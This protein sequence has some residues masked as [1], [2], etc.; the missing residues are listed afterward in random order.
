MLVNKIE[1]VVYFLYDND[2]DDS[3]GTRPI[4]DFLGSFIGGIQ[5]DA[6]AVYRFFADVNEANERSLCW[7]HVRAKSKYASD[8][9]KDKDASW[10]VEQ[11]GRLYAVEVENRI[12]GR[13]VDEIKERRNRTDVTEIL[14]GLLSRANRMLKDTKIH[15]GDMMDTALNYMINGWKDLLNYRHDGRYDIDNTEAERK[16]RPLT[17]GRKNT[18]FFGSGEGVE[19]ATTY[20]TLIETCKLNGLVPLDYLTHVFRQ[21]MM[22]N[23]DYKSLLP[24][25]LALKTI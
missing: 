25:E 17:I 7:A 14:G 1:K 19:V 2:G 6:Y 24:G 22:G 3:R 12:V 18:L 5:T 20:Y 23:K 16:I 13:T 11:I 8:I 10:F 9:S 4:S 21:L 15:F